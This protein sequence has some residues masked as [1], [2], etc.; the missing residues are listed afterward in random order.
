M[1]VIDFEEAAVMNRDLVADSM[2][3]HRGHSPSTS[4]GL[5]EQAIAGDREAWERIVYLYSPLVDRWCRREHL[6]G[7]ETEEIGQVVFLTLYR[8]LA[9][10][11][12]QKPG[13]GFRK[14][15]KTL[16]RRKVMDYLK[17]QRKAPH[18]R[19]GSDAWEFI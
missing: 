14:W 15:L 1:G 6:N 19:G 11:R 13:D 17:A 9:T 16:T 3:K 8:K 5:L 12:K 2:T 7:S 10:F 4:M 18:A